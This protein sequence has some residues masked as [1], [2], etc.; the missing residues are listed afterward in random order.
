M[1]NFKSAKGEGTL[2]SIDVIDRLGSETTISFFNTE[3]SKFFNYI[4][5][6]QVYIFKNGQIK[7]NTNKTFN[8]G[9]VVVTVGR[10]TQIKASSDDGSIPFIAMNRKRIVEI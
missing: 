5:P 3:A 8:K 6:E 4:Q 1:K 2:F 9:E 7:L 10:D